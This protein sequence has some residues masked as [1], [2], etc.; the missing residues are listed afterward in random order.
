MAAVLLTLLWQARRLGTGARTV[1]VVWCITWYLYGCWWA[2]WLGGAFGYRGFI[3]YSAFLALPLSGL[4]GHAVALK[5][6]PRRMAAGI[7]AVL[8]FMNLRL[9]IIYASPW[10]GPDWTWARFWEEMGRA[11]FLG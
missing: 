4:V 3:E 8:V 6:A 2:W 11:F 9:S 10:D 5:P 1:L 7:A